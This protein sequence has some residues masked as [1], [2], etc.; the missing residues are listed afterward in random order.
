VY[1]WGR[2]ADIDLLNTG[3]RIKRRERKK[4][5]RMPV[6]GAALKSPAMRGVGRKTPAKAKTSPR[7]S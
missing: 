4:R 3:E 7:A 5:Q 1:D 2:E 6:D